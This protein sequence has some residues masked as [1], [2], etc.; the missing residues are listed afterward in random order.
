MRC[1]EEDKQ[2]VFKWD[3]FLCELLAMRPKSTAVFCCCGSFGSVQLL[4][5]RPI[6]VHV[7]IFRFP[8]THKGS[9]KD[10]Y[11]CFFV[12]DAALMKL[13]SRLE[14]LLL[15]HI[16]LSVGKL[17]LML[18]LS[19]YDTFPFPISKSEVVPLQASD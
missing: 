17:S 18:C 7:V 12:N 9:Q 3:K 6:Y 19:Y 8:F 13:S 2:D 1:L 16:A 15:K 4:R 14:L 5:R 11:T 10:L